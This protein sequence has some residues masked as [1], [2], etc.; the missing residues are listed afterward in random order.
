MPRM[1][2]QP[3]LQ[4]YHCHCTDLQLLF[5]QA[6]ACTEMAQRVCL[7]S[8]HSAPAAFDFAD[9]VRIDCFF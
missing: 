2:L 3:Q 9:D 6:A 4:L 8:C 7:S 1:Q 5:K